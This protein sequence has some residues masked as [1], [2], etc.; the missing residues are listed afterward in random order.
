MPLINDI[1][2]ASSGGLKQEPPLR[3]KEG[4]YMTLD[5]TTSTTAEYPILQW[6]NYWRSK[7]SE[8]VS[9]NAEDIS[10]ASTDI[11][12]IKIDLDEANTNIDGVKNDVFC[13]GSIQQSVLD[14]TQFQSEMT[15]KWVLMDGRDV[16][17][18]RYETLTGNSTIPDATGAFIRAAGG[19]AGAVGSVQ[20]DA[21]ARNGLG[22]SWSSTNVN[23]GGS[24]ANWASSNLYTSSDSHAHRVY[25]K[26]ENGTSDNPDV[27]TMG[28][29]YNNWTVASNTRRADSGLTADDSHN[30]YFNKNAFNSNQNNHSHTVNK[31]GW[32]SNQSWAEDIETRPINIALYYYIKIN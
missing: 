30:H 5:G 29:Y 1:Q 13:V 22:L 7:V 15:D 27:T 12:E 18:S 4:G 11:D 32:N 8:F 14:E 16:T 9:K 23:T 31:N 26:N 2:W 28:A 21:T 25:Y 17:G 3:V 10:E 19:N 24:K 20:A 6:D